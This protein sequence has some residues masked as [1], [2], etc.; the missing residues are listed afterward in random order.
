MLFSSFQKINKSFARKL[1]S[2]GTYSTGLLDDVDWDRFCLCSD[3]INEFTDVF[4]SM[5]AID[6][7]YMAKKTY[8]GNQKMWVDGTI[9]E[10]VNACT[11]VY[12]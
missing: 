7:F 6:I 2:Q 9:H 5:L 11:T 12:N 4:V 3:N 8:F 1:Q 10:A